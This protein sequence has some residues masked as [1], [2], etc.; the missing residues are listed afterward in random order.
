[1][2]I[3]EMT[4][5]MDQTGD[6]TLRSQQSDLGLNPHNQDKLELVL[7]RD[8]VG[9]MVGLNFITLEKVNLEMAIFSHLE[10]CSNCSVCCK[11]LVCCCLYNSD[12]FC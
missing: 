4:A 10:T 8:K 11:F 2:D 1:M 9:E 5:M 7:V 12:L 3:V 6:L